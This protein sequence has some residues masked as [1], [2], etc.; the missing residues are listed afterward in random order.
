MDEILTVSQLIEQLQQ[1]PGDALVMTVVVKYPGE[2]TLKPDMDGNMRWD[3]GS[4][5]EVQPLEEEPIMYDGQVWI[6][7]ELDEYN[8]ERAMLNGAGSHLE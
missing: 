3:S 5:V 8:P 6:V 2:F 1:F 4:D 7:T